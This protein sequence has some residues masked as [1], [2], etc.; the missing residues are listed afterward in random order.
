MCSSF[1]S[2]PLSVV[3]GCLGFPFPFPAA[4]H[5]CSWLSEQGHSAPFSSPGGAPPLTVPKELVEVSVFHVLKDHDEWVALH[6]DAVELDNV[7]MLEVG[8][9]LS[10][11]VEVL[12]GVVAGILQRL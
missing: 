2:V 1:P 6:T 7:L 9:Q 11:T 4:S 12:A 8:Q 10:F 3:C 5:P